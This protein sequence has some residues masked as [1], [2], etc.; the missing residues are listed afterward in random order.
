[1]SIGSRIRKAMAAF[2]GTD[3]VYVS[4]IRAMDEAQESRLEARQAETLV[5]M[6]VGW[7]YVA[8]FRNATAVASV[9]IRVYRRKAGAIAWGTRSM[10]RGEAKQLRAT[11]GLFAAKAIGD[12][13]EMEEIID[14]THPLVHLLNTASPWTTGHEHQIDRQLSLELTGNAYEKIVLGELATK[15]MPV[16]LHR[17]LPQFTRPLPD[18]QEFVKGYAYGRAHEDEAKYSVAEIIHSRFPGNPNTP[19]MGYPP[20]AACFD[21]ARVSEAFIKSALE[22]MAQGAMPGGMIHGKTLTPTDVEK[23]RQEV[24]RKYAGWKKIGKW[25]VIGGDVEVTYPP[26]DRKELSFLASDAAMRD[27]IANAF[28]MSSALLTMDS[29]ALATASAAL[30]FWQR[31]AILPRVKMRDDSYNDRLVPLFR[32]ALNDPELFVCSDNP[33]DRD[34]AATATRVTTLYGAGVLTLNEARSELDFDPVDDGDE[35]KAPPVAPGVYG[36]GGSDTAQDEDDDDEAKSVH[37]AYIEKGWGHVSKALDGAE[38]SLAADVRG[39]FSR[40]ADRGVL[41]ALGT[42]RLTLE[43][44]D[45]LAAIM[46]A[47]LGPLMSDAALGAVTGADPTAMEGLPKIVE[48]FI[49]GYVPRLADEITR[50]TEARLKAAI[51]DGMRAGETIPQ[52]TARVNDALGFEAPL[53][54]ERIARTEVAFIRGR[55][56]L[57]GM[58]AAGH[59]EKR[60]VLAPGACKFCQTVAAQGAIPIKEPFA[61]LGETIVADDGSTY[62]VSWVPVQAPP[63]HPYDRCTVV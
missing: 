25:F 62:T 12:G 54:A 42:V 63:L 1:M 49:D 8:A 11:A 15:N 28:G 34:E 41:D 38:A 17:L 2:A 53:R 14:H 13:G 47:Q 21:E 52:L 24:H 16:E 51:A 57:A 19:W 23:I 27:R 36:F 44:R 26:G 33:V 31:M 32:A 3:S 9:P 5:N 46:R 39:W 55:G 45:E 37:P 50:E 56:H 4:T 29:A 60:W 30:P 7:V 10:S 48:T 58:E 43:A 20:L 18:K 61:K 6:F 59:K 22:F 35:F 40:L